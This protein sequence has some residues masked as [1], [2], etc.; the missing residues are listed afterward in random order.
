[1]QESSTKTWTKSFIQECSSQKN[2]N[3]S[4]DM[5]K[6][7]LLQEVSEMN[8]NFRDYIKFFNPNVCLY[9]KN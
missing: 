8:L 5:V 3:W 6:I 2:T 1:M 4:K 7:D 9:G